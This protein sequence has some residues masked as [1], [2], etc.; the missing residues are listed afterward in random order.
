MSIADVTEYEKIKQLGIPRLRAIADNQEYSSAPAHLVLAALKELGD[1]DKGR[2]V[3]APQGTVK[4]QV[5]AQ[6]RPTIQTGIG[7]MAPPG[8]MV[9]QQTQGFADGGAVNNLGGASPIQYYWP[10]DSTERDRLNAIPGEYIGK[11]WDWLKGFLDD[12]KLQ[13]NKPKQSDVEGGRGK[14]NPALVTPATEA[15]YG[16]E[17][18]RSAPPTPEAPVGGSARVSVSSS[19]RGGAGAGIGTAGANPL[20][21]YQ[22]EQA[23]TPSAASYQLD[24]PKNAQLQA[25]YEK[26]STPDEAR[27][28]EMAQEK[29]MAGLGALAKGMMKGRGFGAA[30]GPAAADSVAAESAEA[31]KIRDYKDKRDAVAAELG[32]KVGEQAR[33]DFLTNT[34]HGEK[35]ADT[36]WNQA[37]EALKANQQATHFGNQDILETQKNQIALLHTQLMGEANRISAEI[38]RDGLTAAN[39]DRVQKLYLTAQEIAV[40]AAESKYGKVEPPMAGMPL[41]PAQQQQQK[42]KQTYYEAEY[43][44]AVAGLEDRL[45]GA[46]NSM[47]ASKAVI[48]KTYP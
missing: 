22:K 17:G 21:K 9:P 16:N 36:A 15:D 48:R 45:G 41:T 3:P 7:A 28:A 20:E 32:I 18:M 37:H 2:Q 35:R 25:A 27:L 38:R 30:F 5:L 34:E 14:I 8:A 6:T 4:D 24:I 29:Q 42:D 46:G 12:P 33:Q 19:G 44:K 13:W 40:K 43:A 47:A 31:Q 39:A 23:P 1:M 11:G 26:Y 10:G